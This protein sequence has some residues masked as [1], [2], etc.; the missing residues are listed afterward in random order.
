MENVIA[1]LLGF[2]VGDSVFY[3]LGKVLFL[4]GAKSVGHYFIA[5]SLAGTF[6]LF[7]KQ[8][9]WLLEN[10]PCDYCC[11]KCR[12]WTCPGYSSKFGS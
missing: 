4:C 9:K 10:C 3:F 12:R 6:G 5:V 1:L 7:K 11:D 8:S 2:I